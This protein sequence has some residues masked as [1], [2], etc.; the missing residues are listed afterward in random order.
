[1]PLQARD[2]LSSVELR[3][4]RDAL[5]GRPRWP[6]IEKIA[7]RPG[8]H[9]RPGPAAR[10]DPEHRDQPH[11][12]TTAAKA[13]ADRL[14]PAGGRLRISDQWNRR[15]YAGATPFPAE[16]AATGPRL[17]GSPVTTVGRLTRPRRTPEGINAGH[18]LMRVTDAHARDRPGG[19]EGT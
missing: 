19:E 13:Q 10:L 11:A 5:S 9:G 14:P 12:R 6:G 18:A 15:S 1:M 3:A 17:C 2:R 4:L 16:A 7:P 8:P